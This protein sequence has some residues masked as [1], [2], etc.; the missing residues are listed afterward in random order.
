MTPRPT[1]TFDPFDPDQTADPY[2]AY[3]WMRDAAPVYY[4]EAD[5]L[6]AVSRYDDCI[7]V[8]RDPTT[9]SSKLGI[10]RLM[11]GGLGERVAS[12]IGDAAEPLQFLMDLRVLIALDPPDH[13]RLRR[14]VNRPFT[15]RQIGGHETW[16]RPICEQ[17]FKSLLQADAAGSADWVRDFTWPYPVMVIAELLGIPAS[18]KQDFKRWS[19]AL[20]GML[21]GLGPDPQ[22]G[23]DTFMEMFTFFQEVIDRRRTEPGDDLISMLVHNAEAEGEPLTADEMVMFCILLLAAGNETTTNLLSNA[24][25]ILTS[26][27]AV[28]ARL[29]ADPAAIPSAVEEVLRY[30][31]PV[32]ALPR[33]TTQDVTLH[34]VTIPAGKTVLV[35]YGA[36]NRDDRQYPQPDLYDVDRNP[37]NHIGFGNG[38][39]L[40]LGAPLA[41]I[42]AR[43]AL[44]HLTRHVAGVELGSEPVRTDGF[45]L[46]GAKSMPIHLR[47]T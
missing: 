12:R 3:R 16:I 15:P 31:A 9:Y 5:D 45:L 44:E 33:G 21:A 4:L 6:W 10:G 36:A 13:I 14:L 27:P 11:A 2:P 38:I 32:Q 28:F 40:C 41:R 47:A 1:I 46:R 20:V 17:V 39:H 42:E 24:M 23:I 29:K 43:I 18:L 34:G 30:D 22:Q 7:Q 25:R 35:F 8:L 19:D 26:T 37:T